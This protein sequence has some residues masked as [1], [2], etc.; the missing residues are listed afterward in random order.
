MGWLAAGLVWAGEPVRVCSFNIKWLGQTAAKEN[1]VL[2][3][4][5]SAS[6]VV[7][8]QELVAPPTPGRYPN[9][10]A[11]PAD[12]EAAAFFRAMQQ[13]QFTWWLSEEN[14]GPKKNHAAGTAAEWFVV[15]YR[16]NKVAPAP[17]LPHGFL[18]AQR[19]KHPDWDR[20]PYAFSFR[21]VDRSCD[22][23]LISVH[24]H[25]T[26]GSRQRSQARR[27]QELAAIAGWIGRQPGLE[28][29]Y[30]IVGDMNI[31]TLYE[32]RAIR[33]PS[34][35][36]LNDECE[37]TTN[38]KVGKPYDHVLFQAYYSPE[39]DRGFG[40]RVLDIRQFLAARHPQLSVK[41]KEFAFRFSDHNPVV[42]QVQAA[43]DDDE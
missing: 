3:E 29:D 41:P 12:P 4:L 21:T 32:F 42:F 31:E 43:R 15:F 38:G 35:V 17:D 14:T 16:T 26:S 18:S 22:F 20:V 2:A 27:Q 30:W 11:Y 13:R 8:V 40:L 19:V 6:D 36:S 5:V 33:P 37:P 9:G 24:L 23:V 10:Q 25:P 1:G 39:I 7:V 34:F 28:K